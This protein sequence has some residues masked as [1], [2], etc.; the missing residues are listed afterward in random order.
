MKL[1]A[2]PSTLLTQT[3][4]SGPLLSLSHIKLL[5]LSTSFSLGVCLHACVSMNCVCF[6][7]IIITIHSHCKLSKCPSFMVLT[8]VI[9]KI[10][11]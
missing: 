8:F 10:G 9:Y 3:W 7:R 1:P 11:K 6:K 5:A 4:D 2:H